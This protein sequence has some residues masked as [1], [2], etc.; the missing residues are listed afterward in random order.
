VVRAEVDPFRKLK[1]ELNRVDNSAGIW[2]VRLPVWA[3]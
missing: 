2:Q 1:A 3:A